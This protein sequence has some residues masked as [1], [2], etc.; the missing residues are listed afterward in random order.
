MTMRWSRALLWTYCLLAA[1]F[2]ALPVLIVIPMSFGETR[3]LQFPPS[4]FSTRWYEN[5]FQDPRWME[6]TGNSLAIAATVAVVS[7][8]L[9]TM[10]AFAVSRSRLPGR[11]ALSGLMGL[12]LIVPHVVF[13]AALYGIFLEIGL[14]GTFLGFVLAH[15]VLA[16]P[17]VVVNVTASLQ[18]MD[19]RVEMASASLGAMPLVTF[20]RITLPL[21]LPGSLAGAL[22]AFMVSFDEVV[23]AIFLGGPG[24]QT[25]PLLIWSS[26]QF[27]ID[28]T[29]AAVSSML[30]AITAVIVLGYALLQASLKRKA[31]SHG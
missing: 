9:G 28:A 7:A 6:A 14:T 25:L 27:E 15:S 21:I 1:A 20:A 16:V 18:R 23:V 30:I 5:F 24:M 17:Y 31:S 26:V 19:P 8:A 3:L 11:K 12:P 13:G 2:I 4:G 10:L 22:F 29:I